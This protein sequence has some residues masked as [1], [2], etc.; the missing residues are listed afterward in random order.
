MGEAGV[1][2]KRRSRAAVEAQVAQ[3]EASGLMRAAFCRQRG[4]AVGALDK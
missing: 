2:G 1:V 4:L 3:F